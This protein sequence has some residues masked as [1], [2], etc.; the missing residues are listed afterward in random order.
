MPGVQDR[1]VQGVLVLLHEDIHRL[2]VDFMLG[3]LLW[4]ISSMG[5]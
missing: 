5:V 1:L 2:Q 3:Q 4:H